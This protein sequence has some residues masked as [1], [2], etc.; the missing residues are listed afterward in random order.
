MDPLTRLSELLQDFE[1]RQAGLLR[2]TELRFNQMTIDFSG[3]QRANEGPLFESIEDLAIRQSEQDTRFEK[4]MKALEEQNTMKMRVL[5]ERLEQRYAV[6]KKTLELLMSMQ[7]AQ[8]AKAAKDMEL[9]MLKQE[10]QHASVVKD[11]E[12]RQAELLRSV[13]ER[14]MEVKVT[15]DKLQAMLRP[16]KRQLHDSNLRQSERM[17]ALEQKMAMQ[18]Q[19][20]QDSLGKRLTIQAANLVMLETRVFMALPVSNPAVR[21]QSDESEQHE[22]L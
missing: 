21:A 4:A 9:L 17:N 19:D 1:T 7:E 12:L 13:D 6:E 15:H 8:H 11:M 22:S 14:V 20:L 10:V 16:L 3:M 5:E 2:S 18:I